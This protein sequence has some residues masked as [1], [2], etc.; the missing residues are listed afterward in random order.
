MNELT[1]NIGFGVA[2]LLIIG[3]IFTPIF[4]LTHIWDRLISK[5]KWRKKRDW[6]TCDKCGFIG[7]RNIKTRE[8][9]EM[10]D[11]QRKTGRL[12]LIPVNPLGD[13]EPRH[14]K[15]PECLMQIQDFAVIPPLSTHSLPLFYMQFPRQCQHFTTWQKGLSPKEH[16]SI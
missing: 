7:V 9:E 10:E 12:I 3:G 11:N 14:E 6:V 16:R 15:I 2:G 5:I 4:V 1:I 8:L 13:T